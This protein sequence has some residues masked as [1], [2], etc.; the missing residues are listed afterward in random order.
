MAWQEIPL[1]PERVSTRWEGDRVALRLSGS[2]GTQEVSLV[3]LII[4]SDVLRS[5]KL[6][7]T[8]YVRMATGTGEH[9]GKMMFGPGDQSNGRRM[10][11]GKNGN[12]P[13]H[14]LLPRTAHESLT[15][16]GR[17]VF[18]VGYKVLPEG[19][20]EITLPTPNA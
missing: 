17:G 4:G 10:A 5:A 19:A 11:R 6:D 20:L 18:D 14:F 9:A 15:R 7:K 12:T 1:K 16:L 8:V 2:K 13:G 3:N